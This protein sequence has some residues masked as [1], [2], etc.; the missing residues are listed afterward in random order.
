MDDQFVRLPPPL[1]LKRAA[2]FK[3]LVASCRLINVKGEEG[4][5]GGEGRGKTKRTGGGWGATTGGDG[6]GG[7]VHMC[8]LST[9]I[10]VRLRVVGLILT[11]GR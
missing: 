6:D 9:L 2:F 8:T 7:C 1:A 10:A 4:G 3:W 11:L 5:E